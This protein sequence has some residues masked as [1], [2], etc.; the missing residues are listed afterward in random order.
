[1]PLCWPLGWCQ[2]LVA[3]ESSGQLVSSYASGR[4]FQQITRP[5][6]CRQIWRPRLGEMSHYWVAARPRRVRL[7][8]RERCRQCRAGGR[9]VWRMAVGH[10]LDETGCGRDGPTGSSRL[11]LCPRRRP[12]PLTRDRL[13]RGRCVSHMRIATSTVTILVSPVKV[14]RSLPVK[15]LIRKN[16]GCRQVTS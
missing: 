13:P 15:D 1:M 5:R 16:A 6:A 2:N 14:V 4:K 11:K 3:G 8:K 7:S 12:S 10:R 9:Q